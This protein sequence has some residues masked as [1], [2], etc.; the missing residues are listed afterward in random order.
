MNFSQKAGSHSVPEESVAITP[1]PCGCVVDCEDLTFWR[2]PYVDDDQVECSWCG[3]TFRMIDFDFWIRQD[4]T[5]ISIQSQPPL[6]LFEGKVFEA[7]GRCGDCQSPLAKEWKG[8]T[9]H[10]EGS[11]EEIQLLRN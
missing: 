7:A 2:M 4:H 11:I 10:F 3:A 6:F 8:E 5:L 9:V 1:L